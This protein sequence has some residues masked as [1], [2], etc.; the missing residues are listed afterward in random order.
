MTRDRLN[1]APSATAAHVAAARG[2]VD[3]LAAPHGDPAADD[4]LARDVADADADAGAG[5]LSEAMLRHIEGRTRFF[6]R[7]V[8]NA[9]GRGVRQVALLGAGYDGRA[10]RYAAPGVVFFEVDHPA[11]QADKLARLKRLG[12]DRDRITFVGFDLTEPGLAPALQDAGLDPEA[13]CAYLCE[14]LLVYLPPP[15][16]G[17]LLDDL[18]ALAAPGTRLALSAPA[19]GRRAEPGHA[20]FR[21]RVAEL[22]EPV[23][24]DL[25]ADGLRALLIDRRWRAVELSERAAAAGFLVAAPRWAPA[26]SGTPASAGRVARYM[27]TALHRSGSHTLADHLDAAHGLTK[28]ALRERDLGVFDARCADGRRAVVRMFPAARGARAVARDAELLRELGARGFPAERPVRPAP[29]GCHDGQPLLIT[30]FVPGRPAPATVAGYRRLGDLLGQLHALDVTGSDLAPGGAWHHLVPAGGRPDRELSE[31]RELL[32]AAQARVDERGIT[33]Y[34]RLRDLLAQADDCTGLPEALTHAD[35]VT[36]NA[37]GAEPVIIDWAGS[38]HGP[39]LWSLAFLL[40]AAG[41]ARGRTV[42]SVMEGYQAHVA[43]EPEE[44]DRLAGAMLARPV[45]LAAWS[46]VT[47]RRPID[48]VAADIEGVR[49]RAERVARRALTV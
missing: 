27:E 43:L 31:M 18:R 29:T 28:P 44:R 5:T 32:A 17:A 3:R 25:D 35:F 21:A 13:P 34:E 2:G 10:L 7:V 47:A 19:R 36:S 4:R 22:G 46:F 1:R 37:I 39:R 6:D 15:A 49:G 45:V 42:E 48:E 41:H 14:G 12:I 33:A 40:W 23:R 30:E 20:R 26:P 11:T 16:V 8:V 38:G 24:N 9:I